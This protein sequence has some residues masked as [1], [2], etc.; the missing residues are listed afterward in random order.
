MRSDVS[1]GDQEEPP[2]TTLEWTLKQIDRYLELCDDR[3]RAQN[4]ERRSEARRVDDQLIAQLPI[5]ITALRHY[6]PDLQ[7]SP[8][9]SDNIYY[10]PHG[11]LRSL[12]LARKAQLERQQEVQRYLKPRG[13]QMAADQLHEWVWGAVS[14]LWASRHY[15]QAVQHACAALNAHLQ[16]KLNRRDVS[17]TALVRE[18]WSPKD[19]APGRPRLR[20]PDAVP[21]TDEWRSRHLGAQ[22]FGEGCYLGIRNIATH[23]APEVEWPQQLALEKLAALS[24]LARWINEAEVVEAPA[25]HDERA[26]GTV[27]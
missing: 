13:P 17:D 18:A 27:S 7:P 16:N 15:R 1:T 22:Q 8:S 20:F 6:W 23:A 12:V 4:L 19:A 26:E 2:G 21:G 9:Q 10:G 3:R 11:S 5:V 14:T 25:V 24:V